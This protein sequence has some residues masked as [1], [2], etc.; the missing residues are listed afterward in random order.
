[1]LLAVQL[2]APTARHHDERR[3]RLRGLLLR[4]AA[5]RPELTVD[6]ARRAACRGPVRRREH[7]AEDRGRHRLPRGGR[8]RRRSSAPPTARR[9]ARRPG[10][11]PHQEESSVSQIETDTDRSTGMRSIALLGQEPADHP[12]VVDR[13]SRIGARAR[14]VARRPRPPRH[15]HPAVPRRA[16]VGGVLRPVDPHQERVGRR[17]RAARHAARDRRRLV[18]P[19]VARR[20]R[21]RDRRDARHER[22]CD[23][24]PPRPDPR[25]G[26]RVHPRRASRASTT[27]STPPTTRARCRSSTCSAT[28][29]TRPRRW[30]TCCGSRTTSAISPVGTSR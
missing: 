3:L 4:H 12:G 14:P 22:P 11:H 1:M 18:D 15:P 8:R 6:E 27:T 2:G 13:R 23:G 10:G 7:G 29:T 16:G 28:S 5:A 9:G 20:D 25:R 17:C 24:H 21:R 19:G 30:P 26:Q